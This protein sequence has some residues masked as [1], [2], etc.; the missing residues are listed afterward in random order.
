MVAN[1]GGFYPGLM[2]TRNMSPMCDDFM[3]QQMYNQA[4]LLQG[5]KQPQT[6]SFDKSE[7]GSTLVP[8]LE[9]GALAGGAA[10]LGTYFW[11]TDP[12]NKDGKISSALLEKLNDANVKDDAVSKYVELYK[13]QAQPTFDRLN[14]KN[15]EEYGAIKKFATVTNLEDLPEETRKLIPDTIKTPDEAKNLV[16]EAQKELKNID[17]EKILKVANSSAKQNSLS[18]HNSILSKLQS[19]ETKVKNLGKDATKADIEKLLA[20]NPKAFGLKGTKVEIAKQAEHLALR[21]DT[22]EKLLQN[23]QTRITNRQRKINSI[24]LKLESQFKNCW[25]SETKA[26]TKDAPDLLKNSFKNFK[27]NKVAKFGGIA[28][29]GGLI[30]GALFGNSNKAA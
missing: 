14:I 15:L 30:L 23:I 10:A 16:E 8:A 11:G 24:N 22:Q 13:K 7:S 21:Y 20:E 29:I 28:A 19:F 27:W 25:D 9:G 17:K 4:A 3:A 6:D 26:F 18:F 12:F 5:Y 2:Q 1:V